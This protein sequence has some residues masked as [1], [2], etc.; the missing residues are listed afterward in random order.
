MKPIS[1]KFRIMLLTLAFGLAAVPFFNTVYEKW[2][3]IQVD[4]PQVQSETPIYVYPINP[5]F[6]K[7]ITQEEIIQNRDLSLYEVGKTFSNCFDHLFGT[8]EFR[9]CQKQL[10]KARDFIFKH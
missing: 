2:T 5:P 7:K 3:E 9:K 4:L 1:S 6:Y 10:S 8:S